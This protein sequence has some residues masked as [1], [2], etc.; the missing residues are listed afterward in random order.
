VTDWLTAFDDGLVERWQHCTLCGR[1]PPALWG[2]C[3]T[4]RLAI[5]YVLC[6]RCKEQNG[7]RQVEQLFAQRYEAGTRGDSPMSR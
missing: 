1:A 5:A 3:G 2:I 6:Q 4:L 7:V